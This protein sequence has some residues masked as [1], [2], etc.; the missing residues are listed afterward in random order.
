MV[1]KT[2]VGGNANLLGVKRGVLEQRTTSPAIMHNEEQLLNID[3]SCCIY[4][5]YRYTDVK[6]YAGTFSYE[7][8]LKLTGTLSD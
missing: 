4:E 3:T 1:A 2:Q 7:Q 8:L 6:Q 5:L